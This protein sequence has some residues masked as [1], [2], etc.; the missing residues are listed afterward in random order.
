MATSAPA[1]STLTASSAVCTPVEA[2]SEAG[3]SR[4]RIAIQRSGWR[5]SS[6]VDR[7]R[8]GTTSM[9]SRSRSGW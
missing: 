6:E 8:R 9:V 3:T 4:Y 5:S 1:I 2:A 7:T